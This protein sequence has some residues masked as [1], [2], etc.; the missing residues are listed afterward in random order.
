MS[1]VAAI[2]GEIA[3]DWL[4]DLVARIYQHRHRGC[5]EPEARLAVIWILTPFLCSGLILLGFALERAYH[6]MLTALGWGL[7]VFG[8]MITTVGV[9]AY[10][11][12]A[13]PMASG[14]LA[15][16]L[17]LARVAG[18][19]IIGY[20][21][22]PWAKNMG[23]IRSFGIHAAICCGDLFLIIFLQVYGKR[24]RAWSGP[25]QFQTI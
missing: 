1:I 9:T 21:P 17:N 6:Y 8:I 18:G 13:Y 11:L 7:Y 24:L 20:F 15:G 12:D 14:E 23:Q 3:G 5:L 2:W 10:N 19:F 4:H 22:V 16:W 25:P